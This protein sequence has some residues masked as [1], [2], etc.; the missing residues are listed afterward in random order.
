MYPSVVLGGEWEIGAR[1]AQARWRRRRRRKRKRKRK[2][3]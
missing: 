3:S 2:R 1:D